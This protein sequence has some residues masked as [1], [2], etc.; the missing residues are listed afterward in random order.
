MSELARSAQPNPL[1]DPHGRKIG[2]LRV[3]VTDRCNLACVYCRGDFH[4]KFIPH[5]D[6][7]R[8]E[9]LSRIILAAR[10][11]GLRKLRLTGGEPLVRRGLVD[12]L[13]RLKIEAPE[14]DLRLTTNGVLL[15]GK[16]AQLR[17]A[18]LNG[19]NISL[20]TLR[21]EVYAKVTGVDALSA[22]LDSIHE[23]L[24]AG[25]RVKVNAVGLKGV[26][27]A[28]VAGFV[29]LAASLPVDV[30]FIEFMP[31]GVAHDPAQV[32]SSAE[33][34]K[35]A[36]AEASLVPVPGRGG[37][38]GPARMYAIEGGLGRFGVISPQSEHFCDRC[39]RLR[40]TADGR[41]KTCLFSGVEYR[42]R[43][44]LRHPKL[45][46]AAVLKVLRLAVAQK[47]KNREAASA[48]SA[49]RRV[50]SAVGG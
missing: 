23:S 28:D 24:A 7:L 14:L 21:P 11:L 15:K 20:D 27:E 43:P 16:T 36:Q 25:L 39:N 13:G 45:G 2:Y 12:F 26:N 42:L 48:H 9:E 50:M 37:F 46:D 41:L 17:T 19:V 49:N 3:S 35:L 22:V 47:P 5:R 30:R 34:L 33:V 31:L 4:H 38:A 6:I 1:V 8:Y 18:G 29:Q 40:L 32:L 44:L 10:A